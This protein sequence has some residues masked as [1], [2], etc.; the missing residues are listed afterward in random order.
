MG[1]VTVEKLTPEV[2]AELSDVELQALAEGDDEGNATVA[3]TALEKRE[4]E[5]GGDG[6]AQELE[7]EAGQAVGDMPPGEPD[8]APAVDVDEIKIDGTAQLDMFNLGGKLPTGSSLALTGGKVSLID[9][10]AFNK[11]DRI[12]LTIEAVVNDV[13]Q[14]DA[15]DPK[16]GQVV[17]CEQ[18]HK[19]RITDMVLDSAA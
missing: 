8:A 17:S 7:G 19:A 6:K 1:A 12:R 11:G 18:R 5:F 2:A 14:K 4:A 15:H 10:Q 9:G 13:G 16:T 3:K